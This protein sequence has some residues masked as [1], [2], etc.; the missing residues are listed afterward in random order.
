[1]FFA[2]NIIV[3]FNYWLH[4]SETTVFAA[5]KV[6]S[7]P[8]VPSITP[9]SR[10]V[11]RSGLEAYVWTYFGEHTDRAM[12]VIKCESGGNPKAKNKNST[13]T[14]LFQ[15]IEG[16]WRSYRCEGDRTNPSD[17][18]ACAWK[19]YERNG[20]RFNTNG[21]WSASYACHQME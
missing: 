17:N 9:T 21:G 19:I 15:I 4:T 8:V 2:L 18:I 16:T 6:V 13:A 3:P 7:S 20:Y 1:M 5:D 12:K 14:G 11:R 10:Q